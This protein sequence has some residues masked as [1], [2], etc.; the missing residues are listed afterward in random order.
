MTNKQV[1]L[2]TAAVCLTTMFL[3]TENSSHGAL[4][5]S[6]I[7]KY[8]L[9]QSQQGY[10]N[11][12]Q[13]IG[14]VAAMFSS[15]WVI[16]RLRKQTLMVAGIALMALAMIPLAF[17][18][19]FPIYVMLYVIV[20]AAFAYMD[21][22]TS[23]MIADMH[24]GRR[25]ARMMCLLHACHGLSGIVSP[26]LIAPA[27]SGGGLK[28]AYIAIFAVGAALFAYI[29]PVNMRI[30]LPDNAAKP[31][32]LT[33]RQLAEFFSNPMQRALA[34]AILFYGMFLTGM[35]VWIS[36]FIDEGLGG[37]LGALALALLYAGI[38]ASRLLM[39]LMN[40]KPLRYVC[41][42]CAISAAILAAGLLIGDARFMCACA[43]ACALVSG[44]IIPMI[45]SASCA[46]FASN[47][48]LAST[49]MN[50]SMLVGNCFASPL[51]G[52]IEARAG[53]R[54][55]MAVCAGALLCAAAACALSRGHKDD[56]TVL[57]AK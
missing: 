26:L 57:P 54:W 32:K 56:K 16:G 33:K 2:L 22:I 36:R 45:M 29:A 3:A 19:P 20:G 7:E 46:D 41:A 15:L 55:G 31:E 34:I 38:T 47:T 44:A 39:P 24:A 40:F 52:L 11:S 18:P 35:I 5:T 42:S 17:A 4:L 8:S 23:S 53:M 50:L 21:A 25:G 51:I 30:R 37:A 6:V 43:A 12:A 28:G 48:L 27:L 49:L 13:N 14:C 9:T 1:W 10:P